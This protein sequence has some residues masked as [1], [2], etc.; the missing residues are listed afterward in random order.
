MEEEIE[1]I[2]SYK[3]IP[4]EEYIGPGPLGD[5]GCGLQLGLRLATKITGDKTII[6]ANGDHAKTIGTSS[7]VPFIAMEKLKIPYSFKN[8]D[9][10]LLCYDTTGDVETLLE[11][12]KKA[13][14]VISCNHENKKLAKTMA[15]SKIEYVATASLGYI[16]DFLNKVKKAKHFNS[17]FI[18]LFA[19]CP[20]EYDFDPSNTVEVSRRIVNTG[21]F[22]LFEIKNKMWELTVRKRTLEPVE[23][24]YN[25]QGKYKKTE[26][27]LE[28]KQRKVN[29]SWKQMKEEKFWEA[30]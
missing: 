7:K 16:L 3:H 10:T 11:A 22:P 13:D 8:R 12:C 24:F 18:H 28:N 1:E 20:N 27:E 9:E 6:V 30:D 23:V 19:P 25:S 15:S 14:V 29:V 26:E 4:E 21:L 5:T 17:S 2:L